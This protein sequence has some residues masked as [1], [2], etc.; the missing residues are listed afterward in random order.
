[1]NKNPAPTNSVALLDLSS[2][3]T[4]HGDALPVPGEVNVL[5]VRDDVLN[6]RG[7]DVDEDIQ[8]EEA[9]IVKRS[10]PDFMNFRNTGIE[11]GPSLFLASAD[12]EEDTGEGE[13]W[14]ASGD[15]TQVTVVT[16]GDT[17]G[18]LLTKDETPEVVRMIAGVVDTVDGVREGEGV[19]SAVVKAAGGDTPQVM[20]MVGAD[21]GVS[22]DDLEELRFSDLSTDNLS[23]EPLFPMSLE[24]HEPRSTGSPADIQIKSL[25]GDTL[26]MRRTS[27]EYNMLESDEVAGEYVVRGST[28]TREEDGGEIFGVDD[29]QSIAIRKYVEDVIVECMA[30][31]QEL[32]QLDEGCISIEGPVLPP[33]VEELGEGAVRIPHTEEWKED[34]KSI[35][36]FKLEII[37][38]QEGSKYFMSNGRWTCHDVL[39]SHEGESGHI[40]YMCSV[41][42]E[43]RREE[44]SVLLAIEISNQSMEELKFLANGGSNM[45]VKELL[46]IECSYRTMDE[47]MILTSEGSNSSVEESMLFASEGSHL[48]NKFIS[49]QG[50]ADDSMMYPKEVSLE[51]SSC[52]AEDNLGLDAMFDTDDIDRN[53]TPVFNESHQPCL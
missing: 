44:E 42:L 41:G 29:T 11:G 39:V 45:S 40:E 2:V 21:G 30:F 43:E 23:R 31:Q 35:E 34:I 22:D 24:F 19:T 17:P 20:V 16:E 7:G 52:S 26:L 50:V 38:N 6:I 12:D 10:L 53:L 37:T 5:T 48:E 3:L 14:R 4:V 51:L 15:T 1:V 13:V 32:E 28:D 36:E 8:E 46:A 18:E 47:S 9:A 33:R 49:G 27:E 25:D